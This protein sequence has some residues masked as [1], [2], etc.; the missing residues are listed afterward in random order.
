MPRHPE[1]PSDSWVRCYLT[2]GDLFVLPA[3]IYHRF[4]LDENDTIKALR[5]F[6][7]RICRLFLLASFTRNIHRMSQIGLISTATVRQM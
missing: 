6:W 1:H 3:G 4:T 2:A 7:V 5:L